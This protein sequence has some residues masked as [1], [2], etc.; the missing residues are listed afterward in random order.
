MLHHG[1]V[2]RFVEFHSTGVIPCPKDS[3]ASPSGAWQVQDDCSALTQ[4]TSSGLDQAPFSRKVAQQDGELRAIEACVDFDPYRFTGSLSVIL[5]HAYVLDRLPKRT[6]SPGQFPSGLPRF[7]T[8]SIGRS[9]IESG[10]NTQPLGHWKAY[11]QFG[12]NVEAVCINGPLGDTELKGNVLAAVSRAHQA[13]YLRFTS[14]QSLD[15]SG[16][17]RAKRTNAKTF[18]PNTFSRIKRLAKLCTAEWPL[19]VPGGTHGEQ[20]D[21]PRQMWIL[22]K[23]YYAIPLCD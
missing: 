15:E 2:D 4:P 22:A 16:C 12:Q 14:R 7:G 1:V 8:L 6:L 23:Q 11:F 19:K 13:K 21:H 3:T 9:T 20:L 18:A 17:A 5:Q 10:V